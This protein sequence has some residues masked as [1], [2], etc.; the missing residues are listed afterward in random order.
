MLTPFKTISPSAKQ[1]QPLKIKKLNFSESPKVRMM[2]TFTEPLLSGQ[3]V[4]AA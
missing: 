1:H 4:A 3:A 2:A